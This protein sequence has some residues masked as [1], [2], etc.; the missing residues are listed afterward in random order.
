MVANSE[1]LFSCVQASCSL[2]L[3]FSSVVF[4]ATI[5]KPDAVFLIHVYN[6][7]L[8]ES[9]DAG[10]IF[11]KGVQSFEAKFSVLFF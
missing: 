1:S 9:T 11:R 10:G 2:P 6:R 5:K 7:I 8:D 3:P 4:S